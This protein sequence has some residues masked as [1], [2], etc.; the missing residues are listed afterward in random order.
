[1]DT[2]SIFLS[3][4]WSDKPF[5]RRL[6]SDLRD[7]GVS[8]WIDEAEIQVG[9]SLIEKIREG[10]D[11]VDYVGVVLSP[12][13][14]ESPWFQ[15]ELD[16][17]MNQEI[18]GRRVKVLPLLHRACDLPSFLA[19]KLYADFTSEELYP[20][21][22]LK[23][24]NRLRVDFE[25]SQRVMNRSLRP[26][27]VGTF[28]TGDVAFVRDISH[29]LRSTLDEHVA[30]IGKTC[31]FYS[32]TAPSTPLGP[33][34]C[35][36]DWRSAIQALVER[37][38]QGHFDYLV[39]IGSEAC[40]A[41]KRTFGRELGRTPFL[42]AGVTY[43]VKSGLVRR[44]A[45]RR[46]R[47]QVTGIRYGEGVAHIAALI[48]RLLPDRR[49]HFVYELGVPQDEIATAE[50]RETSLFEEGI[51]SIIATN[52]LP[53]LGDMPAADDVYFSWYTAEK[54]FETQEGVQLL[55]ERIFVSAS[56]A[57][58]A[59]RDLGALAIAADDKE[60]GRL[61]G[62]LILD[63]E[64]KLIDFGRMD[65][66]TVPLEY[67]LNVRTAARHGLKFSTSDIAGATACFGSI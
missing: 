54:L 67:W 11:H 51:L 47:K 39:G 36:K 14:I 62:H 50:L 42:F 59:A 43:P 7:A 25:T 63:H 23:L 21:A 35:P 56:R 1:M 26:L 45:G 60:I 65:V 16:V 66:I 10:F 49:L 31:E 18:D 34:G 28:L 38:S 61:T 30:D 53:G 32:A 3:H 13:A 37:T 17:A 4:T 46:D 64:K 33:R 15:K 22:F 20:G 5:V 48:H 41:M 29:S 6:A 44:L 55:R 2:Y 12:G 27:F 58:V 52:G 9:D 57:H 24:A 40:I 8:V 19:G